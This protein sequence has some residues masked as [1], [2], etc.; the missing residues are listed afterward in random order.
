MRKWLH[1]SVIGSSLEKDVSKKIE[2]KI[3]HLE[4]MGWKLFSYTPVKDKDS[5]IEH[6]LLFYSD[7]Q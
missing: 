7:Q 6:C 5:N 4:E 3:R 2:E 1:T